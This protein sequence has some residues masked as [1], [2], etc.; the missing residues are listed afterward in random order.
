MVIVCAGHV[1]WDLTLVVDSLPEPDG[2]ALVHDRIEGGG[3]SAA[4]TAGGLANF[5]NSVR[6]LGS[7]GDD[8]IGEEAQQAFFDLGVD[9]AITTVTGR[10]TS[11]KYIFV[12]EAAD[13]ALFGTHGA[14][15]A[16][17]PSDID[18][19]VLSDATWLHLSGQHPDTNAFLA[20]KA[21]ERDIMVS[22]DPGRLVDRRD[23]SETLQH[24]D[25]LFATETEAAAI[26]ENIE[27]TIIKRG[28]EGA[29]VTCPEGSYTQQ[30][31]SVDAV[32]STGAGDA[33]A[34]GF[35]QS[36]R[37]GAPPERSLEV[38]NACGALTATEYGPRVE[39][40]W[41]DIDRLCSQ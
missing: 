40:S 25:M 24:T 38:G 18:L 39:L 22:F 13:V 12:D 30:G 8:S 3:G 37:D 19:G 7:V 23:Y 5:G 35:I 32:D 11:R 10:E 15:E 4:N 34:A 28:A 16:L 9:N 14:N 36:Y 2:E 41:T 31:F 1:N 27:W 17:R 21:T 26:T 33:F 20:A 6:L 29:T